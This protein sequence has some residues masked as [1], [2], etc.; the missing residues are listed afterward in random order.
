MELGSS[1]KRCSLYN[2][3]FLFNQVKRIGNFPEIFDQSQK[4][5]FLDN[6][7]GIISS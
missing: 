2:L 5:L 1:L 3:K 6:L 7:K 4:L